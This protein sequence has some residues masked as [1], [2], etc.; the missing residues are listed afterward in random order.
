MQLFRKIPS[1]RA[2]FYRQVLLGRSGN[3]QSLSNS[4]SEGE[5][6]IVASEKRRLETF[7][8]DDQLHRN[9]ILLAQRSSLTFFSLVLLV[10]CLRQF[11]QLQPLSKWEQRLFNTLSILLTAIA[12]LGLGSL[13]G[14]MG[15]MLRWPLLARTVYQMQDVD[16]ILGMSSPAGSFRLIKRHIRERKMS[17]TTL[18]VTAYLVTNVIG[19]LSVAIFGLAYNMKDETGI[20]YPILAT[21]WKSAS[22]TGRIFP[23]GTSNRWGDGYVRSE[24]KDTPR[25]GPP[26]WVYNRSINFH[27]GDDINP[28]LPSDLQVSNTT[29]NLTGNTVEYSYILK[30]FQEGYAIP[31]NRTI[32]SAVSCNLIEV[33]KGQYWRWG[34]WN[35][36]GPFG[37]RKGEK[38]GVVPEILRVSNETKDSPYSKTCWMSFLDHQGGSSVYPQIYIVPIRGTVVWEC[39]PTLTETTT[40]GDNGS[41]QIQPHEKFFHPIDLYRLST[42]GRG[43]FVDRNEEG[44]FYLG[45]FGGF[46]EGARADDGVNDLCDADFFEFR[47]ETVWNGY[48]LW[49]AGLVARLPIL[50]IMYANTDLPQF[51]R[52]PYSNETAGTAYLHTTLEVDWLRVALIAISITC[53]QILAILAVLCYCNGV[54]TRDDSHLATAELLKTVITRFDDGKLMTGEELAASLDDVLEVPVSYGT[55]KGQD[56]GPPEVDL[57]S[58]LDANFPPFSRKRRFRRNTN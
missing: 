8:S 1:L 21:N 34:N 46:S 45:G 10:I 3:L 36:T 32:H 41:R 7:S 6:V 4:N 58:G 44:Y 39:W 12:S 40:N 29:L 30:D 26:D 9:H 35:R 53:G 16:S 51:A 19:R 11:S 50:A 20:E 23:E 28:Y 17:R 33:G 27:I 55:R 13:L 15:S 47:N 42:V 2:I 37:W 56:G 31:S 24:G 52:G 43:N 5:S 49:M 38:I 57:A 48:R 22:W 54:Y 25:L 14:H 18:I